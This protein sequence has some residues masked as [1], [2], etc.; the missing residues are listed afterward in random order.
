MSPQG[1][2]EIPG[3]LYLH[4]VLDRAI[5]YV[6]PTACCLAGGQFYPMAATQMQIIFDARF[7]GMDVMGFYGE[8][9]TSPDDIDVFGGQTGIDNAR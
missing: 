7:K 8:P 1:I 2:I 6:E 4:T 3:T 9:C 5:R